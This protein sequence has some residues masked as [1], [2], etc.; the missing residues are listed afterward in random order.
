MTNEP[1]ANVDYKYGPYNSVSEAFSSIPRH[2]RAI[3][4]T[5]GVIDETGSIKEYWFKSATVSESD[6]VPK[7]EG[8]GPGE[9]DVS[10]NYDENSGGTLIATINGVSI[11][12]SPN[13]A[14]EVNVNVSQG[15]VTKATQGVKV[16]EIDGTNL[17]APVVN[18]TLSG[19]VTIGEFY[20]VNDQRTNIYAPGITTTF[21]NSTYTVKY[22]PITSS[23]NSY[24]NILSVDK[25]NNTIRIGNDTFAFM[26]SSSNCLYYLSTTRDDL[27]SS[28]EQLG[29]ASSISITDISSTGFPVNAIKSVSVAIPCNCT[30]DKIQETINNQ[31]VTDSFQYKGILYYLGVPYQ[32]YGFASAGNLNNNNFKFT[33]K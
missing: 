4:L 8:G 22:G 1:C 2:L 27:I 21:E 13:E 17:Y 10:A 3:G 12:D 14:P 25:S 6:L 9:V 15:P 18:P 33:F 11:Y 23:N 31:T 29:S 30:V 32:I 20:K 7:L 16:G 28:P 5:V 19:G 26:K 24:V